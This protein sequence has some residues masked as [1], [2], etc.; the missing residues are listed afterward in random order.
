MDQG[1]RFALLK[2]RRWFNIGDREALS[3]SKKLLL[4]EPPEVAAED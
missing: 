1:R 4:R 2:D 3:R